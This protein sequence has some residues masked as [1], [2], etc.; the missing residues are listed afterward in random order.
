M[1]VPVYLNAGGKESITAAEIIPAGDLSPLVTGLPRHL[2][3]LPWLMPSIHP[4]SYPSA[5][6]LSCPP[7]LFVPSSSCRISPSF[8]ADSALSRSPNATIN[9]SPS[10][11]VTEKKG[12]QREVDERGEAVGESSAGEGV[13]HT[14]ACACAHSWFSPQNSFKY[15]RRAARTRSRSRTFL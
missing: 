6:P 15:R 2:T 4:S 7:L 1:F 10:K 13:S 3:P 12:S 5:L 9:S 11:G 8:P 14:C